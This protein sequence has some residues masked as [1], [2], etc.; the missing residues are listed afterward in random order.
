MSFL[1][2]AMKGEVFAGMVAGS[3][4]LTLLYA[5]KAVPAELWSFVKWRFTC[6][7][8]VFSED[9]AFERVSEWLARLS[10]SKQSRQLRLTTRYDEAS[11]TDSDYLSPGLGMH[12]FWYKR[13]P[14]L[15]TRS[16]PDKGGIGGWKR[17]EDIRIA[18]VG[19]SP[20]LLAELVA[21][22]KSARSL[23]RGNTIDVFLYRQR[24]R[25]ACRKPKRSVDTVVL[26]VGQLDSI[27][28]DVRR[29][30]DARHWYTKRGL[31]YRRGYLFE[32]P[33]GCGKTSLALA[34]ASHFARPIY[35]LNLGSIA[36]D[37]ELIDAVCEVPE[38]GVLLIE[39]IDAAKAGAA[40]RTTQPEAKGAAPSGALPDMTPKEP[41]REV[42]LSAL[43]NVLDGVFARDGRILIMTTNH[44]EKVDPALLRPGR[45]DRREHI[46]PLER[47]EV[48]AMCARFLG[49]RRGHEFAR[50]VAIPCPA[51]E[52]QEALVQE[53][54]LTECAEA[55]E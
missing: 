3:L 29:F 24:W 27:V 35:A 40:R 4:M 21:E 51:A 11:Q 20:A 22:V 12:F 33:P 42:S 14:I 41:V 23:M 16:L 37:D 54:R 25:L 8:T 44:P 39:D 7:L 45:A 17:F 5:L 6:S 1:F 18:T 15:V 19:A 9:A 30:L 55:A 26:P 32:G 34:L 10:A 43:L 49:A 2:Q 50:S 47:E 28:A 46:G 31:P 13:R 38:H 52:L 48:G 36:N 53:A